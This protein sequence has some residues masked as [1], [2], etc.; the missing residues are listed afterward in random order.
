MAIIAMNR[1]KW[2]E[3]M[4]GKMVFREKILTGLLMGGGSVW[5]VS[6]LSNAF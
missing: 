2:E 6:P 5:L 3:P 1:P 4:A